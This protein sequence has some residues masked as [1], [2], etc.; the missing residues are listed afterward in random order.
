M[1]IAKDL[2]GVSSREDHSVFGRVAPQMAEEVVVVS[3]HDF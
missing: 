3:G 1:E 2:K